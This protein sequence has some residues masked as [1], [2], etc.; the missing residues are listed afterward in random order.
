[1]SQQPHHLYEYSVIQLMP[2]VERGELLNIGL[3]MMCK[4]HRWIRV[5]FDFDIGLASRMAPACDLDAVDRQLD[6]FRLVA[7]GTG[8]SP[9]AALEPHERFRWLT[10]VR[11]ACIVTSRPHPGLTDDLDTTFDRLFD[12]LIKH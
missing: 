7:E 12:R 9:V 1:M 2:D 8:E 6:A 10:A 3:A 11:S 4:R 5:G